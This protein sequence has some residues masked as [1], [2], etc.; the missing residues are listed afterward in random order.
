MCQGIVKGG[1]QCSRK[2]EPYCHQ[3]EPTSV[4][5][6]VAPAALLPTKYVR[7]IETKVKKG[8]TKSDK[9]GW[10]YVFYKECDKADTFYKIG[11]T[12]REVE[13]RLKEWPGS[14]LLCKFRVEYNK[15]AESLIHKYLAHVRAFRYLQEDGKYVSVWADTGEAVFNDGK[16]GK[17]SAKCKE[18]EWF[19]SSWKNVEP[20]VKGVC[21]YVNKL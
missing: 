16:D 18:I 8:P 13:K 19:V 5:L 20:F 3:H 4:G 14:V 17:K 12:E 15:L 21:E 6:P 11:R 7:R 9:A 2:K 10:I 1:R